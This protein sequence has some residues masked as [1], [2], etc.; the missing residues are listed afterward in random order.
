METSRS[1]VKR[2]AVAI[3]QITFNPESHPAH[4]DKKMAEY[5]DMV[6]TSPEG[7]GEGNTPL[8]QQAENSAY[9]S[10]DSASDDNRLDV[11]ASDDNPQGVK[12]SGD[13]PQGIKASGDNRLGV[14]ASGDNRL[15][16]SP[17][18]SEDNDD[19]EM[20]VFKEKGSQEEKLVVYRWYFEHGYNNRKFI[21]GKLKLSSYEFDRLYRVLSNHDKQY[22]EVDDS[23]E[24]VRKAKITDTGFAISKKN[25]KLL[26]ADSVFVKG[27]EVVFKFNKQTGEVIASIYKE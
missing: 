25:L 18:E 14:K 16:A 27:K 5:L 21:M 15:G 11:M 19:E 9:Q 22:Y 13:N 10:Q 2:D 4:E 3:R 6:E 12:A 23:D 26:G 20:P 24:S 17:S 1:M 7:T 8:G